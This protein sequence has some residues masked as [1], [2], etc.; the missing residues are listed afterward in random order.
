M[1]LNEP[2]ERFI[3]HNIVDPEGIINQLSLSLCS[4][5]VRN[6]REILHLCRVMKAGAGGQHRSPPHLSPLHIA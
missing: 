5:A 1:L 3:S 6:V 4:A 2:V